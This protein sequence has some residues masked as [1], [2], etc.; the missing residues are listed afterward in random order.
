MIVFQQKIDELTRKAEQLTQTLE[1]TQNKESSINQISIEVSKQASD[2]SERRESIEALLRQSEETKEQLD[3]LKEELEEVAENI[4][5]SQSTSAEAKTKT[6]AY[7]DEVEVFVEEINEHQKQIEKQNTQ[8]E[9]FKETLEKNTAEQKQYLEEALKLIE[10]SKVALSYTTS[11]GLSSSFDAQCKELKGWK[12]IKLWSWL[13]A[14]ALSII[15]V[16]S[17]GVW[18]INGNHNVANGDITSMWMQIVGKISMIPLLVTATIFCANQ[19]S[20][21]KN[22][23]EDYSYKLALAKSMVAFSEELREKDSERYREY[24]SMVLAEIH[25]DPLRHRVDP[26]VKKGANSADIGIDS[27]FKAA[28]NL[29]KLTKGIS[30]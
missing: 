16:I 7:R 5:T 17:I 13:V 21:Q 27:V 1:E 30:N 6:I 11:V 4:R 8:F 10:Q 24:L 14:S 28:E 20:K 15:G 23:L 26:N 22:L 3:S 18:L 29:V 12:N 2:I 9:F 19:Y 25:Q